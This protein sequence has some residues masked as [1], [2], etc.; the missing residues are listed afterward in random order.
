MEKYIAIPSDRL[1]E[2]VLKYIDHKQAKAILG[3]FVLSLSK[4]KAAFGQSGNWLIFKI[5][6]G[7]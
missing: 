5:K 6:I 3:G 2:I 1:Y 7:S 4:S